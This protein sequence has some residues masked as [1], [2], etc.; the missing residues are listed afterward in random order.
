MEEKEYVEK[1]LDDKLKNLMKKKDYTQTEL[2]K[3]SG[4]SQG[5]ISKYLKGESKP[6]YKNLERIAEELDYSFYKLIDEFDL[7]EEY[8]KNRKFINVCMNPNCPG[9]KNVN[10]GSTESILKGVRFPEKAPSGH[11]IEYCEYCGQTLINKCWCCYKPIERESSMYCGHCGSYLYM[12]CTNEECGQV[13]KVESQIPVFP[14]L[15]LSDE[16]FSVF[17]KAKHDLRW[18]KDYELTS[19]EKAVADKYLE[20]RRDYE[21]NKSPYDM[22]RLFIQNDYIYRDLACKIARDDVFYPERSSTKSKKNQSKENNKISVKVLY[23]D[24]PQINYCEVP[25][26]A[27]CPICEQSDEFDLDYAIAEGNRIYFWDFQG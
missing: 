7:K 19:E 5:L 27:G 18:K 20:Q 11:K 10:I 12:T 23:I 9:I 22:L 6:G 24:I 17:N 25:F 21:W 1:K 8:D 2:A 15:V 13:L 4:I 26:R 14:G 16:D 3:K